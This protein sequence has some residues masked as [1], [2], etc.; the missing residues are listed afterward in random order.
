MP[1]RLL[2]T[3]RFLS[4]HP[5]PHTPH[6]TAS[7]RLP[8]PLRIPMLMIRLLRQVTK[9][10]PPSGRWRTS[11]R[12]PLRTTPRTPTIPPPRAP[13]TI[14][15]F[16]ILPRRGGGLHLTL[17]RL[18]ALATATAIAPS[19]LV[20]RVLQPASAIWA[21]TR[22]EWGRVEAWTLSR[23]SSLG[24]CGVWDSFEG[25]GV[26]GCRHVAVCIV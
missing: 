25:I 17:T 26:D 15:P 4:P 1:I 16:S 6:L 24:G 18:P 14:P 13:T 10:Q 12:S 8:N 5:L 23:A 2:H 7:Q 22:Y 9:P 3:S 20:R 19:A 21:P 11:R